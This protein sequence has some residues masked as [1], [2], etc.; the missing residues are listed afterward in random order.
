[1]AIVNLWSIQDMVHKDADGG[2]I[3]VY[4]SL[5]TR[6]QTGTDG[7]GNPTYGDEVCSDGGK[8]KLEY[9]ASSPDFVPYADLTEATVLGWVYNS[10]I[11]GEETADEAKLR[12]EAKWTAKLQEK[13][14]RNNAESDGLPWAS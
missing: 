4:W 9:D 14:D 8:L 11:E 6:D 7:L 12:T 10:L 3:T 13:I 5:Q 1:M 2:V